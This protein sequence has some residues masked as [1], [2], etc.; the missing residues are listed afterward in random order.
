[1]KRRPFPPRDV[2][3]YPLNDDFPAHLAASL[4]RGPGDY[5]EAMFAL[6]LGL[7]PKPSIVVELGCS[8]G[9]WS[10]FVLEK[11]PSI[12]RLFAVDVWDARGS[13]RRRPNRNNFA[14]L[15]SAWMETVASYLWKKAI[16]L[17]GDTGEW[18]QTFPHTIDLLFVDGNH[19]Y[20]GAYSDL[21]LWGPKVRR[22]GAIIV[23]DGLMPKVTWAMDDWATDYG[24][25]AATGCLWY[26]AGAE[27]GLYVG[28]RRPD[29]TIPRPTEAR[30]ENVVL[31]PHPL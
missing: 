15:S 24:F 14:H 19:T 23:H 26:V 4:G 30:P 28:S 16:P 7:I 8:E 31:G 22:G 27:T 1:M 11:F 5:D 18:G 9:T 6:I 25:D 10:L 17:R 29:P 2:W 20:E 3:P 21:S 13:P 12:D